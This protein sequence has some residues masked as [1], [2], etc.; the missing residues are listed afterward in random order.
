MKRLPTG[1]WS[2]VNETSQVIQKICDR[3]QNSSVLI[4][5]HVSQV[6]IIHLPY[7]KDFSKGR[8]VAVI[9]ECQTC[10]VILYLLK[11][12]LHS[13]RSQVGKE[14]SL[15]EQLSKSQFQEIKA[16]FQTKVTQV[17][18]DHFYNTG[19]LHQLKHGEIRGE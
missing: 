11:K 15:N 16:I 12:Q 19:N 17:C 18:A 10:K 13:R 1:F 3:E 5:I 9:A 6:D 8:F 4:P 7:K 14:G 2:V